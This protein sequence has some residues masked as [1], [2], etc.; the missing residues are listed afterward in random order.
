MPR[1]PTPWFPLYASE[2]LEDEKS[3]IEVLTHHEMGIVTRLWAK[4]WLNGVER[5]ALYLKENTPMTDEQIAK[6]L[7]L[8]IEEWG[9]IREKLVGQVGI[10][11]VGGNGELYSKRLR[12]FKTKWELY[13]DSKR[14][15]TESKKTP[16]RKIPERN[17]TTELEVELE[18]NKRYLPVSENLK[19]LIHKNNPK[20]KITE[21]Q[22]N[23]W[24]NDVRLMV[25]RDER[26]VDEI[27]ELIEFSQGHRFW[28]INI[29]SMGALR[30]KFDRLTLEMNEKKNPRGNESGICGACKKQMAD[31]GD[32]WFCSDCGH[33]VPKAQGMA[34][35]GRA[36]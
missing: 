33:R 7:H 30:E 35:R 8:P 3:A 25:E 28:K 24:A 14:K 6:F 2:L 15:I 32:E 36:P 22:V 34:A 1:K 27:I 17:R 18:K 16:K 9:Q 13:G 23:D 19:Q 10:L 12:N 29:L 4:M 31:M 5:G 11:K 21:K 20:A 26:T